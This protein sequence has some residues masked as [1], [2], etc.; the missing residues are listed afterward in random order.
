LQQAVGLLGG[1]SLA[2]QLVFANALR[3]LHGRM[4]DGIWL[5]TKERLLQ[6]TV[7][8][9]LCHRLTEAEERFYEES[10]SA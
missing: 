7:L 5:T 6:Y 3:D 2:S 10:S 9:A 4:P 8:G 1:A